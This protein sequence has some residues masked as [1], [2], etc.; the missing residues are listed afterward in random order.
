MAKSE[1]ERTVQPSILDRL[2]DEDPRSSADPRI[3]YAESLRQ[4]K[5]SV[6]RDLEWLLNTRRTPRP[7]GEEFEELR[8]SLYHF[9]VPDI[10]SLSRDALESRVRLRSQ[11]EEA[12]ALFEPRLAN[13]SISIHEMDGEAHRRELRFTVDAT[14]R[15]DPTPE[16]VTFDTVLHFSSGQIDVTRAADA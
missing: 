8:N 12:L 5:E 4:F 10:T 1:I 15:L 16:Q 9:G 3:T 14:L 13:V 11:V 2:T 7:A 6:Q